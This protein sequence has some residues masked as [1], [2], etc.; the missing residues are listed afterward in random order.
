MRDPTITPPDLQFLPTKCKLAHRLFAAFKDPLFR[1]A[2]LDGTPVMV[3]QLGDKEA[4][5][6]LISLQRE[7]GIPDDSPDGRMVA[8]IA[9]SLDF[10]AGLRL[11]DPLP[12][13]V[14]TGEAS[15]KPDPV[16]LQIATT[17]LKLQLIE[18][19]NAGSG[20]EK[21]DLDADALLQ[22]ADDPHL[23]EQ[24]Q[25]AMARAA[26]ALGADSSAEVVGLLENLGQELAY[27]EALRDRLL[28][29]LQNMTTKLDRLPRGGH[30]DVM[31]T[32]RLIQVRRLSATALRRIS[33]R[34]DDLDAQ[35]GEVMS[36]L[37]N[38]EGQRAFIRSSR[39]WLYPYSACLGTHLG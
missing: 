36:A 1:A 2:E 4:A 11:D 13:E 16:H 8:L 20:T 35:T 17:R 6:P 28:R 19:L 24:V 12:N 3:V 33:T 34:F 22:V 5:L 32:D 29:R 39:D 30:R 18:W 27:I 23:R 10:V 9:Q 25:D 15:W 31:H 26:R 14:L 38:I 37:R 21:P 7:F